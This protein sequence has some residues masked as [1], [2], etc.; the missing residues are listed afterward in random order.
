MLSHHKRITTQPL[1]MFILIAASML[2]LAGCGSGRGLNKADSNAGS[3]AA[4]AGLGSLVYGLIRDN[5]DAIEKAA[6]TAAA[7]A[8]TTKVR[9]HS[10]TSQQEGEW[11]RVLGAT[12][13]DGVVALINR[14]YRTAK[15]KF[16]EA[17]AS[18]TANHQRAARWLLAITYY[19]IGEDAELEPLLQQIV[20]T[21]AAI[22]TIDKAREEMVKHTKKLT[23]LRKK[24]G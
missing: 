23:D 1:S 17:L 2:F 4:A 7:T 12:N 14:D 16:N 3:N 19:D 13:T 20:E 15:A 9:E 5:E 10:K 6:A 18:E 21:D 24:Y 22:P 8:T 11:E